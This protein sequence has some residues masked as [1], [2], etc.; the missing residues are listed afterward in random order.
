MDRRI[1]PLI[2]VLLA[3]ALLL[4][5]TQLYPGGTLDDPS[6]IG[7]DWGRNYL[8]QLF[9]PAALSGQT[10]S[11]RPYAVAGLWLFC[12]G[13]A[14]LFRQLANG[15]ASTRHAKWVRILGIASMV[16]AALT[17]TRMHDLMVTISSG[18][19]VSV[20]IV[21]LDW[22]WRRRLL[23]QWIA[24]SANLTLLLAAMFVYYGQIAWVV[25]P[26]LQKLSFLSSSA[27]LF[28]L[29]KRSDVAQTRPASAS[30]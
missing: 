26:T 2:C 20:D 24:G 10:N 23:P 29:L 28:W 22:L 8:T 6:A 12:I 5:A 3:L 11:A 1:A 16:Y 15:M 9:R 7:F 4:V 13:M 25:L 17:V 18:F 27:W 30:P 19:T 14:E 21:L